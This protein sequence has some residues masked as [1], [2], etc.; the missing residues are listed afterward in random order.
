M[1]KVEEILELAR[2]APSG[3]NEQPWR[4]KILDERQFIVYG[5]DTSE[6]CVYDLDRRASQIALGALLQTII[7]AAEGL[8]QRAEIIPVGA[9]SDDNPVFRVSIEKIEKVEASPL[10]PCIKN[11]VTQRRPLQTTPITDQQKQ[12]LETALGP[13]FGLHWLETRAE[14]W[15]MARLLFYSAK[16][17]LTIPEAYEVHRKNIQWNAQY[18]EDRLPDQAIGVDN[19]TLKTMRWAMTSWARVQ[20]LNKWL[21]GTLIPRIQMDLLPAYFCGGHFLITAKEPLSSMEDYLEGGR[22]VQR[23]WLTVCKQGLLLQPEM[24]PL[25]FSRFHRQSVT[26]TESPTALERAGKVCS[27]LQAIWQVDEI[28]NFGVFQ[29]RIGVGRYPKSRSMRLQLNQLLIQES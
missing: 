25:I 24:T 15:G 3:D 9:G 18:S 12:E 29:G 17:R 16:I 8:G 11:R 10:F 1:R 26:F 20:F 19:M 5:H 27:K 14:R 28:V 23:F 22:A 7:I 2:W 21:G 4:F 13:R 6:W